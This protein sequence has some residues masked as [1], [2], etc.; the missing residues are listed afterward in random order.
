MTILETRGL[1]RHF[2]GVVAVDG[3]DFILPEGE[4]HAIIGPNGAGK[5]TFVSMLC[6]RLE[7]DSGR[8]LFKGRDIT[9]LPAWRRVKLGMAYT[10][11]VTSVFGNLSC[12]Q[13]VE[14][15]AQRHLSWASSDSARS[16]PTLAN[17]VLDAL[18]ATGLRDYA[19]HPASQ[20]S[21]GHQRLLEV[22]MGLALQPRLLMLDEP[23]QGLSEP[24]IDSFIALIKSLSTQATI[25]LIEHNMDVVMSLADTITVFDEGRVLA[26]GPPAQ[27]RSNA[28]V[29]RAYLGTA[30]QPERL[31]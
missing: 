1:S 8:I 16:T 10:F 24:E 31:P 9:G 11:Q 23:T 21:Y 4:I 25:L 19:N 12:Y 26:N 3:V 13:N 28:S 22:S 27:I 7:P 5:S 2:G 29:Q 18:S 14:L 15:A 17:Q 6:G 20:I 30:D